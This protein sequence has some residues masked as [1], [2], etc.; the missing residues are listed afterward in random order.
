M[1]SSLDLK[2]WSAIAAMWALIGAPAFG[3]GG[4]STSATADAV[5]P[6]PVLTPYA[7]L[8]MGTVYSGSLTGLNASAADNLAAPPNAILFAPPPVMPYVAPA[9][10]SLGPATVTGNLFIP[11]ANAGA[12]ITVAASSI[13]A[14]FGGM[15]WSAGSPPGGGPVLTYARILPGPGTTTPPPA[16]NATAFARVQDPM[17][18][19]NI[20]NA[21]TATFSLD[22]GTGASL[23]INPNLVHGETDSASYSGFD[24]TT[25]NGIGTLWSWDWSSD[26]QN[27]GQSTFSFV[28][29][30]LLGLNDSAI[31]AAFDNLISF[32]PSSGE[33]NLTSA[34]DL[35]ATVTVSPGQSSFVDTGEDDVT[36]SAS[37]P[38]HT[39]LAFSAPCALILMIILSKHKPGRAKTRFGYSSVCT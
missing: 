39:S 9:T 19:A 33:F 16:E 28:S 38:D 17:T 22:I 18:V 29:N 11:K 24:T 14:A 10:Y 36:A 7:G 8:T 21:Q 27:P 3:Q 15:D 32:D 26:S 1:S 20:Q 31:E 30:P 35:S 6:A 5:R 13:A 4:T 34:L 25:L 23:A 2:Q 37:V 12:F